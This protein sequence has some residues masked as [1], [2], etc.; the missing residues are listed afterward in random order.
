MDLIQCFTSNWP[1][2]DRQKIPSKGEEKR[3]EA[4][5]I[6][7]DSKKLGKKKKKSQTEILYIIYQLPVFFSP[8]AFS[9]HH[10][11]FLRSSLEADNIPAI[12][13]GKCRV[14]RMSGKL[15]AKHWALTLVLQQFVFHLLI[16][17]S[18][19]KVK[20]IYQCHGCFLFFCQQL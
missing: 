6:Y 8:G 12:V 7:K 20:L 14:Q 15:F 19:D 1:K 10:P 4:R 2:L 3:Q 5:D 16:F 17:I 9:A 11:A 18:I 13:Q